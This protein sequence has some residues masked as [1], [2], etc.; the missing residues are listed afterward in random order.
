M[1]KTKVFLS[2]ILILI[3]IPAVLNAEFYKCVD[4]NGEVTFTTK[5]GPGCTLLTGS[6]DQSDKEGSFERGPAS[7]GINNEIEKTVSIPKEPAP[8]EKKEPS[9]STVIVGSMF[10]LLGLL[11]I[12]GPFGGDCCVCPY[13]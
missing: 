11:I 8:I 13:T 9:A 1:Q 5:P 3:L 12:I 4:D 6:V 10:L 2:A 7:P